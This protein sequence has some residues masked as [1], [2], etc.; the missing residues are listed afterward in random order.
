[1]FLV[2]EHFL[3]CLLKRFLPDWKIDVRKDLRL[4]FMNA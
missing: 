4:I 1:M 3:K 2:L